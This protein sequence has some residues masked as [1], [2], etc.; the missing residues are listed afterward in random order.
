MASERSVLPWVVFSRRLFVGVGF[1]YVVA[2][3]TFGGT[4]AAKPIFYSTA[5][6]VVV[7]LFVFRK[8][9]A[10]RWFRA[11]EMIGWN[12]MLAILL[13]ELALRAYS[14]QRGDMPLINDT[15]DAYRLTPGKDYGYGLGGN[16]LGYPGNDFVREK[17]PGTM[18]IAALG[19]SFAVG[20]VVPFADNYL[21]RLQDLIPGVEVYN[22]GVSAAGP[23]EYLAI[24]RRD[25]WR[26]NPDIVLISIFIGNDITETL[27]TPRHL[28]PRC[29]S[30]YLLTTRAWRLVRE[31]SRQENVAHVDRL[32]A[33]ALSP[34][35]Y[36][37]VEARRLTV[38][39][40][41]VPANVEKKWQRA[42]M[43]FDEI[44]AECRNREVPLAVVLIPD[45]FQV[46]A[47]VLTTALQYAGLSTADIDLDAPQKRLLRWFGER[48]TPVID[49]LPHFRERGLYAPCDTHWN[50]EGNHLAADCVADWLPRESRP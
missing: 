27:A 31:R 39:Q 50:V 21:T 20:P 35:T 49:L 17:V 23:R 2:S 16:S 15:L 19:D 32:S 22:F 43:H 3:L 1:A 9:K 26:F 6:T 48:N 47:E 41:P 24:L 4:S 10:P 45:E 37:E 40:H 33:T 18:R 8:L 30:L 12:L 14:A 29:H 34:E 42:L 7:A 13:V 46:S 28:D 11:V 44:I 25:V 5:S 36:R 38:C